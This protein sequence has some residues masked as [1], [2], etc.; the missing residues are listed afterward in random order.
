MKP[1]IQPG[2]HPDAELLTAFA[3]QLLTG[4]EREEIL[5]HMAVCSR[6]REVVFL[7]Q[8][9]VEAEEPPRPMPEISEGKTGGGWFAN[10]RWA[11]IPVAALAGVV[12]FAVIEHGR[13]APESETR[14]AQNA[15]PAEIMQK[16]APKNAVENA[17]P[18]TPSVHRADQ[19]TREEANLKV[20]APVRSE[21]DAETDRKFLDDKDVA[22]NKEKKNEAA[23]KTDSLSEVPP[24]LS[25]GAV[26]GT[27]AA[28]AK[29]SS[30]GG[31]LA[32][33]Q[34][35]VQNNAQLQQ[36]NYANEARQAGAASDAANKPLSS[37]TQVGAASQ[38]V[39]VNAEVG[40]QPASPAPAAPPAVST[41]EM[42]VETAD[43]SNQK[44]AKMKARKSVSPSKLGVLSEATTGKRTIAID[45][46]G[47]VFQSEEGRH[48]QLVNAQW[49]GRAVLVKA[50]PI[51]P[52][53]AGL[54]KQP[55][56]QFELTTDKL[57][58]WVSA[59][60]KAW[61]LQSP[62]SK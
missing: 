40:L 59:D 41:A 24:I 49:S 32:Q 33:N 17:R 8:K 44:L 48:W 46:A 7:A 51:S 22:A 50:L 27:Y 54:M 18:Q 53:V 2:T 60:G 11:W 38:T 4:A 31:P 23:K 26:H 30:V 47:T 36:Q 39:T 37:P 52:A 58:T 61:V 1:I 28:R 19:S 21:R 15:P 45:T 57:E 25:G 3:E 14:M 62:V 29:S 16:T 20:A 43:L 56:P 42:E 12:G 35:Q 5:G 9:A 6:C 55:M 13:H 10:W 34:M